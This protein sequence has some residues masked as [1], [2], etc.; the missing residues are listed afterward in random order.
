MPLFLHIGPFKTGSTSIQHWIHRNRAALDAAGYRYVARP[1]D[2]NARFYSRE[3]ETFLR[4]HRG[5]FKRNLEALH[6]TVFRH[7]LAAYSGADNA[8][9]SDE[10]LCMF[11][12]RQI[13][14]LRYLLLDVFDSVEVIVYL[15]RQDLLEVSSYSQ[16]LRN[17][18]SQNAILSTRTRD[19]LYYDALLQKW[20]DAFGAE[21]I[22][23]EVMEPRWLYKGDLISDFRHRVGV[24][25][26]TTLA[27]PTRENE[28]LSAQAQ[29]F[30]ATF[31]ADPP[32][33]AT[34]WKWPEKRR[35]FE[36]LLAELPGA[37]RR[38][39]RENARGFL[40]RFDASNAQTLATWFPERSELFHTDFSMY[41]EFEDDGSMDAAR[42]AD[43]LARAMAHVL[44]DRPR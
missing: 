3:L 9:L 6:D 44:G 11:N 17:G 35:F 7:D 26:S 20:A 41:P 40:K 39:S 15:R 5:D 34:A 22:Q 1:N 4:E 16:T 33:A 21:N 36:F 2:T 10:Q 13:R 42:Y 25:L 23:A 30:L 37:P 28:A 31:N 14:S 43:I 38:P 12:A 27:A 29:R 24:P 32:S 8:I 19:F 18:F